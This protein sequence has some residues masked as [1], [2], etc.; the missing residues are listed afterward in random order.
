MCAPRRFHLFWNNRC[1]IIRFAH[2]GQRAVVDGNDAVSDL[3]ALGLGNA[4]LLLFLSCPFACCAPSFRLHHFHL[5]PRTE[6]DKKKKQ[7][8]DVLSSTM[9]DWNS[10]TDF[11][12][13]VIGAGVWYSS[14]TSKSTMN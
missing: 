13:L 9:A 14:T 7:Y 12:V 2:I 5:S 1:P 11:H 8:L 4:C 3:G 10:E 6:K